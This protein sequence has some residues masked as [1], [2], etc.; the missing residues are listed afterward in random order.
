M[1]CVRLFPVRITPDIEGWK[2]RANFVF[3]FLTIFSLYQNVNWKGLT[4]ELKFF[5]R[6]YV[7]MNTSFIWRLDLYEVSNRHTIYWQRC[8]TAHWE[9]HVCAKPNWQIVYY[10]PKKGMLNQPSIIWTT[11]QLLWF[12]QFTGHDNWQLWGIGLPRKFNRK[13]DRQICLPLA[14]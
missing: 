8:A 1:T 13:E 11:D 2:Q 5:Y 9:L 4:R 14:D 10:R 7:H 3:L 12:F 6:I